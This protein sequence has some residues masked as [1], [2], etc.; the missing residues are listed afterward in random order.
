MR[1]VQMLMV[2]IHRLENDSRPNNRAR[3]QELQ[4]RATEL[5]DTQNSD[6]AASG[7]MQRP[8]PA[9]LEDIQDGRE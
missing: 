8:P 7:Q 1:E 3:I 2:E 5:S 9:Y 4:Q 6:V